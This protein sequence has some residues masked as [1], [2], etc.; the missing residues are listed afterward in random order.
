MS[1]RLGG[2]IGCRDKISSW[3]LLLTFSVL[4]ANPEKL[5]LYTVDHPAL[6]WSAEQRKRKKSGSV[7]P[8]HPPTLLVRRKIKTWYSTSVSQALRDHEAITL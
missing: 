5:V 6:S 4:V 7:S 8:P 3:L 1:K 2:I